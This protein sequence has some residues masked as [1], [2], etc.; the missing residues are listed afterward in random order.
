MKNNSTD[1]KLQRHIHKNGSC[2][3]YIIHQ[4]NEKYP[5]ILETVRI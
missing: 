1:M 2:K 3:Y 5:E 4:I